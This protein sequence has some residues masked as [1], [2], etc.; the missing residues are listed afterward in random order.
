MGRV[1]FQLRNR[2]HFKEK[3]TYGPRENIRF[4]MCTMSIK[5]YP[6]RSAKYLPTS[7]KPTPKQ[8]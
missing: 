2:T 5:N 3:G 8:G 6:I 1:R 7:L 4:E